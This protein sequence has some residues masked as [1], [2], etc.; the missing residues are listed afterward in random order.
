MTLLINNL[1]AK[2]K[3]K[4]DLIEKFREEKKFF[5]EKIKKIIGDPRYA[6]INVD[7][8]SLNLSKED[9]KKIFH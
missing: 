8:T 3:E 1:K 9:P 7:Y 6:E 4:E 2:I 5:A